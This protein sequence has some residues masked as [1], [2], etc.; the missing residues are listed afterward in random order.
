MSAEIQVIVIAGS[1]GSGKTTVMAE[2]SDVLGARGVVH[3]AIDLDALGIGHLPENAATDVAYRNLECVWR[4]Y[5]AAGVTRLLL[6][7]A[8]EN[9]TEL[10]R[11]RQAIP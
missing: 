11:I 7:E 1:M 6:A 2:A 4:N 8:I 5:L 3:A 10:D 9:R